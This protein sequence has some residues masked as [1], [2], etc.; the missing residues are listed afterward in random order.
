[1]CA[2][3]HLYTVQN[4]RKADSSV[5]VQRHMGTRTNKHRRAG[6]EGANPTD[7]GRTA[8]GTRGELR[9]MLES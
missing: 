6:G 5:Q 1:M 9:V 7:M 3:R 4:T 2:V 8:C